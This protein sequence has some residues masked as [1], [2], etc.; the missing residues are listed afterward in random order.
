[1]ACK[2]VDDD[3]IQKILSNYIRHRNYKANKN[4]NQLTQENGTN[5]TTTTTLR[6]DNVLPAKDWFLEGALSAFQSIRN[7]ATLRLKEEDFVKEVEIAFRKFVEFINNIR[8]TQIEENFSISTSNQKRIPQHGE[9]LWMTCFPLFVHIFIQLFECGHVSNGKCSQS[10][11]IIQFY[12]KISS[13]NI[14]RDLRRN[15]IMYNF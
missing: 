3:T 13:S 11:L 4:D 8:M 2:I 1:M 7:V 5:E 9:E 10:S 15:P 6:D 14:I 12:H